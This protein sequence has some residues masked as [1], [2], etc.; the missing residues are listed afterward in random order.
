MVDWS[1]ALRIILFG[2]I[3]VFV[4]LIS[5]AFLMYIIEK[6]FG[7]EES[8]QLSINSKVDSFSAYDFS[9]RGVITKGDQPILA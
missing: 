5:L 8:Q 6:L 4:I 9:L 1:F 7:E 3:L 2:V